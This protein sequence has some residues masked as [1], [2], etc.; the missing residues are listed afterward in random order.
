MDLNRCRDAYRDAG[1]NRDAAE[2]T[3]SFL[4]KIAKSTYDKNVVEGVGGFGAVYR[5]NNSS[6]SL[7]VSSTDGVGTKSR[8]SVALNEYEKLGH[9]VVNACVNDVLT[10]G[11]DPLF[12]LD[13]IATG[14]LVSDII[15]RIGKGIGDACKIS[16]CSLIG[17]ETAEMPGV[18][19]NKDI[20]IVGFSVGIVSERNLLKSS[21]VNVGDIVL[22]LASNGIHTNG[23]SLIRNKLNLDNESKLLTK[24]FDELKCELGQALTTPHKPYHPLIKQV[25][26]NIKS[27]AHIT[28]GGISENLPRALPSDLAAIINLSSWDVPILFNLLEKLMKVDSSE[29]FRVFNMG[30]GMILIATPEAA[31]NIRSILPEV[32]VI[33]EIQERN[34]GDQVKFV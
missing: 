15:A 21:S 28:G 8:I 5:L 2:T 27:M 23:F 16:E 9:D 12:F 32:I 11:A 34:N 29:M 7:L 20:E 13:Y 19:S 17:G 18:Y 24:Y 1:V 6:D 30:L 31:N 26:N 33:G 22:G 4:S 10:T 14:E 3:V 25:K